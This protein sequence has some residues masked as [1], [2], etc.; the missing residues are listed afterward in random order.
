MTS[1]KLIIAGLA[2]ASFIG[3]SPAFADGWH[4]RGHSYRYAPAP[5]HVVVQQ[6][7]YAPPPRRVVVYERPVVVHRL[8][9]VYYAQPA[10]GASV[11][12]DAALG[13]FLG[14]A[15]GA[16]IGHEIATSY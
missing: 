16:F 15:V 1:K 12:G 13:L 10:Y 11:S 6:R 14:A 9:P 4:G 5:R 2:A 8:A 3:T 7:Y